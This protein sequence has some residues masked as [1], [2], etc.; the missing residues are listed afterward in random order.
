M[1]DYSPGELGMGSVKKRKEEEKDVVSRKV[2][3][4]KLDGHMLLKVPTTSVTLLIMISL[5]NLSLILKSR[6]WYTEC[7]FNHWPTLLSI[8]HF[9]MANCSMNYEY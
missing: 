5:F 3:S 6:M 9:T 8:L 2:L 1:A 7:L 4:G